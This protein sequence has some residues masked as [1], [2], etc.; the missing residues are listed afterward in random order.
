MI[1][2][3]Q[4]T[5]DRLST[6]PG[7]SRLLLTV[8]AAAALC[9]TL[10]QAVLPDMGS[11]LSER[12]DSVGSARGRETLATV[13]LFLAGCL[14]VVASGLLS[15]ARL[16]RS[17]AAGAALL[18]LGGVWLCAGRAAFN[19]QMLKATELDRADGVAFLEA[20]GG[21]AFAAFLPTLLALLLSGIL[22]GLAAR[23]SGRIKWLPL[24]L[25]IVGIG[26]FVGSEFSVKPLEIVGIGLASFGLLLATHALEPSPR[27]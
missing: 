5:D 1:T 19:L 13:L 9:W 23:R 10:G 14:Y 3:L 4:D 20:S 27:S 17:G 18:G 7:R 12:Y 6:T 8:L 26:L 15:R 21:P 25:W 24:G 11:D 16:S 22:L 2:Q